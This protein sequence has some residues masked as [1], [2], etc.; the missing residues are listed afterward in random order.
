VAE[1]GG[2]PSSRSPWYTRT[3]S[4]IAWATQRNPALKNKIKIN[5][6]NINNNNNDQG[7]CWEAQRAHLLSNLPKK[8][9]SFPFLSHININLVFAMVT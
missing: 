8:M 3:S 7:N 6:N 5:N 4:R 2:S 1:T 9:Y